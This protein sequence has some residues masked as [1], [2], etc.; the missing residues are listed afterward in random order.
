[1]VLVRTASSTRR[2]P[3]PGSPTIPGDHEASVRGCRTR[4]RRSSGLTPRAQ[5]RCRRLAIFILREATSDRSRISATANWWH[6]AG[7]GRN[8][9]EIAEEYRQAKARTSDWNDLHDLL[10]SLPVGKWIG[11]KDLVVHFEIELH[12]RERQLVVCID[13]SYDLQVLTADRKAPTD[14][15]DLDPTD[16]NNPRAEVASRKVAVQPDGS[17][18]REASRPTGSGPLQPT[19]PPSRPAP[20]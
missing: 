6:T 8:L 18:S 19:S 5:A 9:A 7:D 1:L 15:A 12:P 13:C 20:R 3:T 14:Y 16:P 11:C 17:V 4:L 2:R 10:A